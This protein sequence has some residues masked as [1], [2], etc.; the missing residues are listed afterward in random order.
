MK[1][2]V[3]CSLLLALVLPA[4]AEVYL[5]DVPEG[6]YAYDA[7]YDL[8]KQ[9]ITGGFPDGTFRGDQLMTRYDV[10]A[11]ISKLVK[12]RNLAKGRDEKLVEELRSEASL[13]R[14]GKEA[15]SKMTK[16]TGSFLARWRKPKADYRLMASLAKNFSD[17]A[18]LTIELDTLDS[19]FGGGPR[20]LAR[21]LLVFEGK[22]KLGVLVLTITDGPGEVLRTPDQNFPFDNGVFFRRPWRSVT[23]STSVK[24]T[25]L[26]LGYLARS[27]LASGLID[28][29]EINLNLSQNFSPF[30]FSVNPRLFFDNSGGHD[31]RLEFGAGFRSLHLLTGIAKTTDYPHNL[32][33]RG[34]L[35]LGDSLKLVAQKVG[36]QYRDK[37]AYNIFDLFDRDLADGLTSVGLELNGEYEG[38]SAKA[39]GDWTEPGGTLSTELHLG[40]SLN[41]ATLVGIT[42]Q[43]YNAST[44]LGLEAKLTF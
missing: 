22:I 18:G 14:Y 21:E 13:L 34:E 26:S 17:Q 37:F 9:G 4:T 36:S 43:T 5:K 6:H 8:I 11:F 40:R 1:Y 39:K 2:F 32:Y 23:F 44:A 38:W 27:T 24:R 25:D 3:T 7:V 33:L 31:A 35:A 20:D 41:S 28:T 30:Y 10:A 12:S 19:G 15:Q 42:G 29:H 16:T